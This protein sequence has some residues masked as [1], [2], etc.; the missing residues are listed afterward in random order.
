MHTPWT[1]G[2]ERDIPIRTEAQREM[3][4]EVKQLAGAGSLIPADMS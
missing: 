4:H 1:L 3:L 2:Q